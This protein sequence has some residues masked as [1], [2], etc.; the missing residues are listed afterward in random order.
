MAKKRQ[1]LRTAIHLPAD[2]PA[3]IQ[4]SARRREKD[5]LL[6]GRMIRV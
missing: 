3:A 6:L 5:K 1:P 4:D 2:S